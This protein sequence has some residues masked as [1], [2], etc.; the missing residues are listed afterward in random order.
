MATL[1]HPRFSTPENNQ[2]SGDRAD[3]E[4]ARESLSPTR[5]VPGTWSR[6]SPGSAVN[7][8]NDD[9]GPAL[10]PPSF[11][12]SSDEDD[13]IPPPR[14]RDLNGNKYE[15]DSLDAAFDALRSFA[16][17]NGFAVKKHTR[18]LQDG[19][20]NMQYIKTVS[21]VV[22]VSEVSETEEAQKALR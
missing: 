1:P 17:E 10:R 18:K 3:F 5:D 6:L 4:S 19:K 7:Q 20:V 22:N 9:D 2:I 16:K 21:G 8:I 13:E 12:D 11:T 15:W 14:T